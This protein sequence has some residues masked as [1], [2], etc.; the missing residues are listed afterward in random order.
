MIAE[1]T[2]TTAATWTLSAEYI[3]AGGR[4]V[5]K[6]VSGTTS[7]YHQDRLSTRLITNSSGAVTGTASNYAYGVESG[8]SG[9]ESSK[10]RFASYERDSDTDTDYAVNRQYNQNLG[11]FT[12]PDPIQGRTLVPQSLNRYSYS[13]SDPV[14]LADPLGLSPD[15]VIHIGVEEWLSIPR[16]SG[17]LPRDIDAGL[18]DYVTPISF[19]GPQGVDPNYAHNYCSA[20]AGID[21]NRFTLRHYDLVQGAVSMSGVDP[22]LLAYTWGRETAWTIHPP[23]NPN[24]ITRNGQVVGY[25]SPDIGPA[26]FNY[27]WTVEKMPHLMR[28]LDPDKT[29]GPSRGRNYGQPFDG[30]PVFALA[31][32]GRRLVSEGNNAAAA[33]AYGPRGEGR[34]TEFRRS[35]PIWDEYFKCMKNLLKPVFTK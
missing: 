9:S 17:D 24:P 31:L 1:Y 10:R 7:Y 19:D 29:L 32:T 34:D 3:Y 20:K 5:A 21:G 6:V 26:H 4:P 13:L 23:P 25:G 35:K 16:T 30:D 27:Y 12:R 18:G 28:G 11:R 15:D 22:S 33:A 8:S 14:N 2:S